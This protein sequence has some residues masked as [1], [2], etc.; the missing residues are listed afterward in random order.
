V[1]LNDLTLRLSARA[2]RAELRCER[3][4]RVRV[5][6]TARAERCEKERDMYR[7]MWQET[8]KERAEYRRLWQDAEEQLKVARE[9]TCR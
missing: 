5:E 2:E 7:R 1:Q 3:A 8:E 9:N 6:C 4:E